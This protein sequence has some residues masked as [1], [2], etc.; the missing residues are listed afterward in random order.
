ME[1][2]KRIEIHN[3]AYQGLMRGFDT[4]I[5]A[6]GYRQTGKTYQNNVKE[7]LSYLE[8]QGIVSV[9]KIRAVDMV[10]YYEYIANRP[11]FRGVGLLK[12]STISG[13]MFSV[14]LF[15]DYLLDTKLLTSKIILPRHKRSESTQRNTATVEEILMIYGV[16]ESKRDKV[17]L[18]LAYGCGL[19][20]RE[21]QDLNTNDL[22]F[23]QNV[24]IVRSGKNSKRR[25]IP[26]A[27][28]IVSD[29]KC[30]V[31]EERHQ[32]LNENQEFT[33][34]FLINKQGKRMNGEQINK[35]LKELIGMVGD[36][37]LTAKELTLHCL[38]H[39]IAT[40]LLEKGASFDFVRDFLGHSEIDTVHVYARRRKM[41]EKQQKIMG[42]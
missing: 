15:F 1:M 13:K 39:S 4:M 14:D 22:Q 19:R 38:R 18:S 21:M 31:Y 17:I 32:Y 10:S 11:A 41:R 33:D 16:C 20:R 42:G 26:L 34:A 37:R 35:R 12:S 23:Q 6:K 7:F 2:N 9:K 5:I 8:S 36:P 30:Y 25:V 28:S 3:T 40:H 24:L 27:H 29:L